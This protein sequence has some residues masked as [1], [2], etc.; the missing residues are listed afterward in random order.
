MSRSKQTTLPW[1]VTSIYLR[2]V[3]LGGVCALGNPPGSLTPFFQGI[4]KIKAIFRT[5]LTYNLLFHLHSFTGEFCRCCRM[6]ILQV[7]VIRPKLL[8]DT[9]GLL[10]EE[11]LLGE[12]LERNQ[13]GTHRASIMCA[14]FSLLT[15]LFLVTWVFILFLI[16]VSIPELFHKK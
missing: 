13:R 14:P 2:A 4:C 5:L 3:V 11:C 1:A 15:F 16:H 9:G 10:G 7:M 8:L 6:C 12:E